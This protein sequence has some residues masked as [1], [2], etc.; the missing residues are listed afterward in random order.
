MRCGHI[1]AGMELFGQDNREQWKVIKQWI[2]ESDVFLIMIKDRYGFIGRDTGISYTQ[3]EFEYAMQQRKPIIKLILGDSIDKNKCDNIGVLQR[4][5][6]LVRQGGTDATIHSE[7]EFAQRIT[8]MLHRYSEEFQ[9][10]FSL[11]IVRRHIVGGA[12]RTLFSVNQPSRLC[13]SGTCRRLSA[14]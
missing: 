9:R 13:R 12:N 7:A 14:G 11:M 2:D 5:R 4:F 8:T 6:A 10:V 3:M 1:P